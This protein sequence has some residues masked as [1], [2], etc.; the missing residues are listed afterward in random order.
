MKRVFNNLVSFRGFASL[1]FVILTFLLLSTALGY[2]HYRTSYVYVVF[3]DDVELGVVAEAKEI[4]NFVDHLVSRCG[5][6]YGLEI[7]LKEKIVLNREFRA[8]SNPDPAAIRDAIRQEASFVTNAY[9]INVDGKPFIPVAEKVVLDEVVDSLLN[10]YTEKAGIESSAA[11]VIEAAVVEEIQL[12]ECVVSPDS[13]FTRDEIIT[14]LTTNNSLAPDIKPE[15]PSAIPGQRSL[16]SSRYADERFYLRSPSS[17]DGESELFASSQASDASEVVIR[18]RTVEAVTVIESIPF[19]VE[20]VD[21]NTKYVNQSEITSPGKDGIKEV[22]YHL[23]RDN[24]VEIE[25]TA[26]EEIILEEPETQIESIGR[27]ELATYGSSNFTWPVQG[28]GIIYPNQGFR[29]GHN[30]IDI[31]IAH[32]TNVLAADSGTVVYSGWGSTQGNY[33]ILQHGG[34]WTLYLH[35]S[36]HLVKQGDRVTRGQAIAK[37]GATGRATGSHLHFEVRVDDGTRQ[38]HSYYQHQPV[39]PMQF[40]RR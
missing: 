32:G 22:V 8:D 25:R 39:D 9:L 17:H 40:Y 11:E 38:W 24:G 37:V 5:D 30:G 19:P 21:D 6:L 15:E 18:V 27:K 23:V 16:L 12:E 13:L 7:Q 10:L 1:L 14:L 3:L 26:I 4:Q 36:A 33:L 29:P 34:Y 35:N 28:E 2:N 20:Y 31:H